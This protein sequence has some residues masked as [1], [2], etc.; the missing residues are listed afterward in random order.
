MVKYCDIVKIV[1]L[2]FIGA[3]IILKLNKDLKE[4]IDKDLAHKEEHLKEFNLS[5]TK[6]LK[7]KDH[8][9][10]LYWNEAYGSKGQ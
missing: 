3:L 8:K 7:I 1:I 2:L 5:E 10:I 4:N 6:G 9:Y